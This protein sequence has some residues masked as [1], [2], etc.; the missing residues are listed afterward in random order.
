MGEEAW[1]VRNQRDARTQWVGASRDGEDCAL[2]ESPP[3]RPRLH[4]PPP[5]QRWVG[6]WPRV[7]ARLPS[8]PSTLN[9]HTPSAISRA[10]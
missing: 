1:E 3:A 6:W 10:L 4:R 7:Q 2:T 8:C 9:T 5:A